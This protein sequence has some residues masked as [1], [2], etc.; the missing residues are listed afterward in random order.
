MGAR[1]A[2][3]GFGF[4]SQLALARS[5]PAY[6]VGIAFLAISITTF[7]SLLLTGGY[8][9][10]GLTYLAR[11]QAWGRQRLTDAFLSAALRDMTV[12]CSVALVL[13]CLLWLLPIDRGMAAAGFWGTLAAVPL[14]VIRLN[15]SMANAQR[16]FTLSYAPDFVVRPALLLAFIGIL[17]VLGANH[18]SIPVLVALPVIAA[19]VAIVQGIM[20]GRDNVLARWRSSGAD[21]R[22]HYRSR[23]LAMLAVTIVSGATADL[24]VLIAGFLLRPEEVAVLGV[25]IRI[26]ALVGFF[27]LASQQF[28]L[29]DLVAARSDPDP[30]VLNRLL[31]RT[32]LAGAG[33]MAVAVVA[34][35]LLGHLVLALFGEIYADAYPPMVVFLCSQSVRVLGGLNAQL[36]S[37]GGHQIRSAAVCMVA[38]GVLIVGSFVMTPA[39]GVLGIAIATLVAEIV[40][41]L[42]LAVLTQ[43]LEGRRADLFFG[44]PQHLLL[45]GRR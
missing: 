29:R 44:W 40:W 37:L 6:E 1:L 35:L 12:L 7:V 8:H 17:I 20:L 36:L 13:A 45:S 42:G 19:A 14:A 3:A 31:L 5:F 43:R 34:A 27:A 21:L 28:A 10:I 39:F 24:V 11:F 23:A 41:A 33:T 2:G 4:L 25:G 9:T 22:R 26:A 32:N 30:A 18:S 15:N 38:L 16:R